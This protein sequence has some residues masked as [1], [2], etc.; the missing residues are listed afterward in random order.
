MGTLPTHLS[1]SWIRAAEYMVI[2]YTIS[3]HLTENTIVM[4][5]LHKVVGV[6]SRI[7]RVH[8]VAGGSLL[9]VRVRVRVWACIVFFDLMKIKSESFQDIYTTSC[10]IARN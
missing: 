4:Q 6:N 1:G 5:L 9:R 3:G 10:H 7:P 8:A 2:I